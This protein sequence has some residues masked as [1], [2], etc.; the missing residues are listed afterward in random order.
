MI[1]GWIK[2][3]D[4]NLRTL[5]DTSSPDLAAVRRMDSLTDIWMPHFRTLTE[6]AL[7]PFYRYILGT[8]KP[9][10]TYYYST[11]GNEKLKAPY[12][13]YILK[14]WTCYDRGLRGLG[15]WAAGQYYGDPYCRKMNPDAYDTALLY[16]D[17]NGVTLSRRMLAWKRGA[18]DFKLLKLAAAELKRRGS[19]EDLK[20][21]HE[22]VRLVLKYPRDPT[23]A[24]TVRQYCRGVLGSR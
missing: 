6:E 10:M 12:G 14:F 19:P 13:D 11:G 22:N 24:E 23:K 8:G 15:Y 1:A 4:P 16:P 20:T 21:L 18:Q 7:R 17:E 5:T 9:V 2:E 3:V